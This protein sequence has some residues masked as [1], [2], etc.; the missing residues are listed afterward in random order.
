VGEIQGNIIHQGKR[1]AI[2]RAFHAKA[3]K[4]TIAGWQKKINRILHIFN[5]RSIDPP[6]RLL[7]IFVP[8]GAVNQ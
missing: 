5:V 1:H 7:R 4:D 6:W 8:D 2:S 3:D